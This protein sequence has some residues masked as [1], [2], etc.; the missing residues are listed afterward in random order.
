[1]CL[2]PLFVETPLSKAK[3][4][5][6]VPDRR[7]CVRDSLKELRWEHESYGYIA[8]R[9]M[10][11]ASKYLLPEGIVIFVLGK[12]GRNMMKKAFPKSKIE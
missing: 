3:K 8:H 7:E 9:I 10:G 2:K 11:A 5:L 12:F 6:T 1:M 4:S